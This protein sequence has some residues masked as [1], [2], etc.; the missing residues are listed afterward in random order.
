MYRWLL[1]WLVVGAG[2]ADTGAVVTT[3]TGLFD[4][5]Q[6]QL[7]RGVVEAYLGVPFARPPVGELR[8][9]AAQPLVKSTERRPALAFAPACY[10]G[11][12]IVNW[13]RR[14]I[15]QFGGDTD[16]FAAPAVSEDCLYLNI[17]TPSAARAN[18][19]QLP[20]IV[21]IHGGSNSGG[22]SWEPNYNGAQLA[23]RGAVVVSVAYRLG[24]FGFFAHPELPPANL[25]LSD[26]TVA[27]QWLQD[28]IAAFG[29]DASRLTLVG[30]SAGASNIGQL[31]AMPKAAALFA[32]V[33]HQSA[34][35]AAAQLPSLEERQAYGQQLQGALVGA[36][37]SL[38]A[39]RAKPA[40]QVL[41][42]AA[43]VFAQSGYSAQRS[44]DLP[45]PLLEA[46]RDTPRPAIDLLIGTNADEWLMYLDDNQTVA[47]WLAENLPDSEPGPILDLLA[48]NS[49]ERGLDRLITAVNFVCPSLALAT[50]VASRG[51]RSW[52]YYFSRQRDGELAATMGAYHGA[53]L[54]YIFDSHDDWLPTNAVDRRLTD[55]MMQYWIN[56][57]ASGDPNGAGLP[58][59]PRYTTASDPRN[60][61]QLGSVIEP[62]SHPEA[63][64]CQLLEQPPGD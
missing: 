35:W 29:G 14:V 45:R 1:L 64:L 12:H 30:E 28:N 41:E 11:Q 13:Y 56:F 60:T 54:P 3:D 19:Q 63:I 43:P 37:G 34:G 61:L 18:G 39:M 25:A 46:L 49:R 16:S 22:W 15:G 38:S 59:W 21:Y 32:R 8:W 6:L 31:M 62:I 9:V 7:Q 33:I 53:E 50:A 47:A 17:W 5:R 27:L 26:L 23:S 52:L 51:D 44:P 10:Q 42:A 58:H 36:S 57:A 55:A 40:K 20:V 4:G 2:Q 24:P 48:D